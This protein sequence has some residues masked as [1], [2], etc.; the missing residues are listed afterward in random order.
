MQPREC[1]T[2]DIRCSAAWRL[3][4]CSTGPSNSPCEARER[5]RGKHSTRV[6][7]APGGDTRQCNCSGSIYDSQTRSSD[8]Q[9]AQ[10]SPDLVSRLGAGQLDYLWLRQ[11]IRRLELMHIVAV[12]GLCMPKL[13]FRVIWLP[14]ASLRPNGPGSLPGRRRQGTGHRAAV[15]AS[16][17]VDVGRAHPPMPKPHAIVSKPNYR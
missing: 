8:V 6:F 10:K 16:M 11:S 1:S 17:S 3:L 4:L 15:A 13:V 12:W 2:G 9:S 7:P 14:S 5:V